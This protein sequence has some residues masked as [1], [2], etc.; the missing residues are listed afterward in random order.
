MGLSYGMNGW[1]DSQ[2]SLQGSYRVVGMTRPLS[3]TILL[4]ERW[5]SPKPDP[6]GPKGSADN[7]WSVVPPYDPLNPPNTT[8]P[9]LRVKH[10]A[11]SNYL[12]FDGHIERLEPA[13]TYPDG[14]DADSNLWRLR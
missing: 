8:I 14:K 3:R 2:G 13:Q 7:N 10:V 6:N 9:S 12:F 11:S 5:C 1:L 4:A